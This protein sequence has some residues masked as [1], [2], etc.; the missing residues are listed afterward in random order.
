MPKTKAEKD[1]EKA[2]ADA[3]FGGDDAV[4]PADAAGVVP[5]V[6]QARVV[7]AAREESVTISRTQFDEIMGRLGD[8]E[9]VAL[10]ATRSNDKSSVF[11]PLAEVKKDHIVRVGFHG[12]LL[13]VGYKEKMHPDGRKTFTWM[14]KD[15]ES[16]EMRTYITLLLRNLET[17]EI[18]EETVDYVHALSA[19]SMVEATLKKRE[20][21]G[22]LIEQ[23]VTQQLVWDGKGLVPTGREIMTG[24]KEQKF[25]FTVEL[26]GKIYELP[27]SVINIKS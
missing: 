6:P 15:K 7:P 18:T 19:A 27:E 13:I 26:K 2:A 11:N 22:Q 21:I 23:G 10:T 4:E 16:G 12:D 9:S 14:A 24:A 1:A 8:L 25:I 20:D 3:I 5:V 17:D